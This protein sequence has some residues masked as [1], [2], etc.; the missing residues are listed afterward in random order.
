MKK[1]TKKTTERDDLLKELQTYKENDPEVL[2]NMKKEAKVAH[3]AANRW[4][5]M[6]ITTQVDRYYHTGGRVDHTGGGKARFTL[7]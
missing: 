3:E 4:T 5:G 7:L 2:E 1:L 6:S